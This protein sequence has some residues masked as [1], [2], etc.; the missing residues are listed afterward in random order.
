VH[1]FDVLL[2]TPQRQVLALLSYQSTPFGQQANKK[3]PA[4]LYARPSKGKPYCRK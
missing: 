3:I 1:V 2:A 4:K